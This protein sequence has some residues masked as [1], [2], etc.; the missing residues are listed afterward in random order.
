MW[1]RTYVRTVCLTVSPLHLPAEPNTGT[2]HSIF[3]LPLT[4]VVIVA[5]SAANTLVLL[6]SLAIFIASCAVLRRAK[7]SRR[8]HTAARNYTTTDDEVKV[9]RV[10]D[11][12]ESISEYAD[13]ADLPLPGQRQYQTLQTGTLNDHQYA[14]ATRHTPHW[15]EGPRENKQST[16]LSEP[17][18]VHEL[19]VRFERS[20][21]SSIR[22]YCSVGRAFCVFTCQYICN[23]Y[24][25]RSLQCIAAE[26]LRTLGMFMVHFYSH[27][28]KR[29]PTDHMQLFG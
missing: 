26:N 19:T 17:S 12:S 23:M 5:I 21:S 15:H 27:E 16:V 11:D 1:I 8:K 13:V 24:L 22:T 14:T 3:S 6:V 4:T 7:R 25:K 18:T 28:Y 20:H 2:K 29:V 10:D 9:A